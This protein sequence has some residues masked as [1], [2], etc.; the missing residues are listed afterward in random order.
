MRASEG[1]FVIDQDLG[2][3]NVE[4]LRLLVARSVTDF[5]FT[6][7]KTTLCG[8]VAKVLKAFRAAPVR[9]STRFGL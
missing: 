7:R 4:P 6:K 8:V 1:L 9:S 3:R 5:D 2:G